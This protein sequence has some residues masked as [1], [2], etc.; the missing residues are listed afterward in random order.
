MVSK[1]ADTTTETP[2]SGAHEDEQ[3]KVDVC[4]VDE[5]DDADALEAL[6]AAEEELDANAAS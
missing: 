4:P 2:D 1:D 6:A 5:F 3:K